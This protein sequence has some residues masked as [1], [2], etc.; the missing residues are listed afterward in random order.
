MVHRF[1]EP[2]RDDIR[3]RSIFQLGPVHFCLLSQSMILDV[4][5]AE[6][7]PHFGDVLVD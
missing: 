6:F 4:Y 1:G 2:V 7:C 5:V 3:G